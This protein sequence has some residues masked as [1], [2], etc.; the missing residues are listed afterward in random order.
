MT[1]QVETII[2]GPLENNVYIV[3][4]DGTSEA[5]IIDP[6][7]NPETVLQF[8]QE[9]RLKV[10]HILITHAHFDHFYGVPYLLQMLPSIT[11]VYLHKN[12]LGNWQSGGGMQKFV[13]KKLEVVAP[14]EFIVA[15][16]KI[17]LAQVQIEV[18]HCP[19]HSAGSV[20]Y[21]F[22]SIQS[23]FVGDVIFYHSVGRTDLDDGDASQLL[24][25]ISTQVFTLPVDTIL[26]PGHGPSTTVLEEMENN[27]FM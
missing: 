3:F 8:I 1:I 13:G 6:S 12:D 20:I 17:V 15:G 4:D 2:S 21:Y 25:S 9:N 10:E 26:Y 19:G 14:L 11:K 22:E 18:R 5:V 23:A 27:P 7:M 16:Q 24:H